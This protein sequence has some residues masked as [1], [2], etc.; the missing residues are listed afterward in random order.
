MAEFNDV[1]MSSASTTN[2]E[3][4]PKAA[5][6]LQERHSSSISMVSNTIEDREAVS[7][8]NERGSV[9]EE[10]ANLTLNETNCS[11]G[12]HSELESCILKGRSS[13]LLK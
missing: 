6:E 9:P 11:A 3:T 5:I 1:D 2:L 8:G 7:K 10:G 4:T 13:D 12:D